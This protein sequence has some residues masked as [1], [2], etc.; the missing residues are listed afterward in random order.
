MA[1]IR[2]RER[3]T[4]EDNDKVVMVEEDLNHGKSGQ[5]TFQHIISLLN[6]AIETNQLKTNVKNTNFQLFSSFLHRIAYDSLSK[7]SCP[8]RF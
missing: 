5:K 4:K 1:H 7:R 6:Y 2:A 3:K 8:E